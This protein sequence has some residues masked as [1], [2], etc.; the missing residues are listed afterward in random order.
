MKPDRLFVP[1]AA[2]P[3]SWFANGSKRWELRQSRGPWTTAHVRERRR[4]ELRHGYRDPS[5]ALWGTIAEVRVWDSIDACF[6]SL[7]FDTVI[8]PAI[9]REA[10]I[11]QASDI[12]AM[13]PRA[14]AVIG[15]RVELDG[16]ESEPV[17]PLAAVYAPKVLDGTKTSTIRRGRRALPVGPAVVVSSHGER[18]RVV[19]EGTETTTATCLEPAHAH[20][21]GFTS[22]RDLRSALVGFYPDLTA[23]E[24]LTIVHFR[25]VAS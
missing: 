11:R 13:E 14:G 17:L 24:P 7:P 20:R 12:L 16:P 22:V 25:R 18:I 5:S 6:A 9:S 15:F 4:V 8:P 10:A 3:Y 1:L 19:I 2:D 21:D 23:D